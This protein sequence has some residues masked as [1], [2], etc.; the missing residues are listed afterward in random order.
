M[1][2][3][4]TRQKEVRDIMGLLFDDA[5][6]R[7]I[8]DYNVALEAEQKGL[9]K[10]LQQGMQK[11]IHAGRQEGLETGIGAMVSALQGLSIEQDVVIRTLA[12]KFDLLPQVAEEKVK[13]YW[14]Q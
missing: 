5:T 1:P 8:H 9:Q 4:A 2:F 14:V 12:A 7:E 11:G 13:Q 3:L 6:I 10:G